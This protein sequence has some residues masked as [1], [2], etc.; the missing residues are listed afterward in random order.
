MVRVIKNKKSITGEEVW[1]AVMSSGLFSVLRQKFRQELHVKLNL[2]LSFKRIVDFHEWRKSLDKETFSLFESVLKKYRDEFL[3]EF[4]FIGFSL[5]RNKVLSFLVLD[6]APNFLGTKFKHLPVMIVANRSSISIMMSPFATVEDLKSIV[7]GKSNSDA[8]IR[9]QRQA[10]KYYGLDLSEVYGGP[11]ADRDRLVRKLWQYEYED[12]MTVYEVDRSDE[13]DVNRRL[14]RDLVISKIITCM[15]YPIT[16]DSV[17]KIA[18]KKFVTK[19]LK[20]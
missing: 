6:K 4:W 7:V 12:L 19:N 1:R 15:G 5:N 8:I 11:N 18:G 17:R 2:K 13:T 20:K 3:H 9:T 16:Q 10:L 14:R